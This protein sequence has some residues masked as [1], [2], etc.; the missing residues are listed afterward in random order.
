MTKDPKE[1]QECLNFS[2][3]LCSRLCH[4]LI[5]PVGA[6]SNGIEILREEDDTEMR[7]QVM[8]LLED[9]ARQTSNRLQFFRL[10]FGAA[11]GFGDRVDAREAQKVTSDLFSFGKT[12]LNWQ[13]D[14]QT[15]SK[16]LVKLLLNLILIANEAL[17]RGGDVSVE[18]ENDQNN[19]LFLK[20]VATGERY[21]LAESTRRA[22]T[23]GLPPEDVEPRNAPAQ[24]A[25]LIA[26]NVDA[27][28]YIDTS[29]PT[30]FTLGFSA[31]VG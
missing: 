12:R 13:P 17:I 9:S 24:L 18:M 16:N 11:G 21:I 20:V 29:N 4:D 5:S 19:G 1:S 8:A 31:N 7:E 26:K 23:E 25:H 6:I 3:L 10:A 28:L 22:F 30:S 15:M 27:T 14:A 2:A